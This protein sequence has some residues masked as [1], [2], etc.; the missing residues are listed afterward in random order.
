MSELP[1]IHVIDTL[2][3]HG[4]KW[5]IK[6]ITTTDDSGTIEIIPLKAYKKWEKEIHKLVQSIQPGVEK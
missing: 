6:Q 2:T 5:I 1:E 3:I 4:K